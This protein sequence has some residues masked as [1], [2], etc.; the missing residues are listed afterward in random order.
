MR[1]WP[2]YLNVWKFSRASTFLGF[3]DD[4]HSHGQGNA[5]REGWDCALS[6]KEAASCAV[7]QDAAFQRTF[8]AMSSGVLSQ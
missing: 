3:A 4:L 8:S 5:S 1:A 6:P 7:A 2:T